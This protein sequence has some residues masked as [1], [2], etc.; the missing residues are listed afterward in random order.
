MT[1]Q[2]AQSNVDDLVKGKWTVIYAQ[3]SDVLAHDDQV[4]N[5]SA[6]QNKFAN[7]DKQSVSYIGLSKQYTPHLLLTNL[8]PELTNMQIN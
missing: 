4:W 3:W 2:K 7:W 1:E 5:Y 6:V 8:H